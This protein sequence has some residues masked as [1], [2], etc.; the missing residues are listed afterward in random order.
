MR[1]EQGMMIG[2]SLLGLFAA[3]KLVTAKKEEEKPAPTLI[4]GLGTP[5]RPNGTGLILM[6]DPLTLKQKQYYRA[7]M[8]LLGRT[9]FPFTNSATEEVIGKALGSMGFED[10]RVFMTL[11]DLPSDWPASTT[12]APLSGV[13]WFQGR[14]AGPSI[15]LPRPLTIEAMWA[16]DPPPNAAPLVAG[17]LEWGPMTG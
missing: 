3:Y 15:S 8:L 2:V 13:R 17:L 12:N 10:V 5:D 11:Q 16:T 14:W 9:A 1:A 6:G 4:P 7:R